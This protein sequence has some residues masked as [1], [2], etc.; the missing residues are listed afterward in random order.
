MQCEF[1][2]N[3]KNWNTLETCEFIKT[4]VSAHWWFCQYQIKIDSELIKPLFNINLHSCDLE[5]GS[6]VEKLC[7]LKF[8]FEADLI[9]KFICSFLRVPI[10][11][12]M[13]VQY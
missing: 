2:R 3:R 12:S 10:I 5:K 9:M 6:S 1:Y 11:Q 4:A 13:C 8:I 7:I